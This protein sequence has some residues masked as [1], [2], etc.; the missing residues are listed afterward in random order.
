MITLLRWCLLKAKKIKWELAIWQFLD[1]Q[2]TELLK[3]PED[4]E[5]KLMSYLSELIH[6]ASQSKA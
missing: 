3:N 2:L 1:K 6:N 5:Q 4:L